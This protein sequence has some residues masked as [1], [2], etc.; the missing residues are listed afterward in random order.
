MFKF[1]YVLYKI[2]LLSPIGL[3]RLA[4]AVCKCGINLMSLLKYA[5]MAYGEKIALVY[6]NE[7]ITYKQLLVESQT[8]SVALSQKY[9][10]NERHKVGFLCRN[11]EVMVKAL[12]A[13]SA[14]G[15]N[16][17]LLNVEVSHN[18]F[19]TLL[20]SYDID[21]LIYDAEFEQLV[22]DS[23]Y[24]KDK[25]LS[26]HCQSLAMKHLAQS[27]GSIDLPR[28]IGGAIMML[29]GG[30]TGHF[31]VAVHKPSVFRFLKPFLVLIH[32]LKLYN[33]NC[34]YIAT[35]IYH[36]YG[37]SMLLV[38]VALGK[39]IVIDKGYDTKR[40]CHLIDRY[41][42]DAVT[43]VPLMLNKMLNEDPE[44]LKSLRC[45]ASGG[46]LLNSRLVEQT[47]SLLGDVLYNLY[48]TSEA[49][50]NVIATPMDLKYC[51][52]T[53]GKKIEGTRI[54]IFDEKLLEK[55]TNETGQICIKNK[56]S[57]RIGNSSWVKTGDLGYKDKEGYYFLC[58][59]V[60]DMIVSAGENVYPIE[61]ERVLMQHPQIIDAAVIG[62]ADEA[63]GQR[64]KA[65]VQLSKE[66]PLTKEELIEW[67]RPNVARFQ[68]PKE[69][70][71]VESIAYTSLFK[72]DIKKLM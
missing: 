70:V 68:M 13:V 30:T 42:V 28:N 11:H 67:L 69:I 58:G 62:V 33:C 24:K 3:F 66:T 34:A 46:A 59:R 10:L 22:I 2:G 20:N 43:V 37:I 5:A 41:K 26:C 63:F 49:G 51:A 23:N 12:F 18:Q 61:V 19:N 64:L 15:A 47:L 40:A 55:G 57:T 48:G 52:N 7:T 21:L 32:R 71:F 38:F 36:G 8:L 72:K 17:Y 1:V 56:W 35:P 6:N 54:K 60:D 16:I 25:L 50:L 44:A 9:K 29:T 45:I 4:Y 14:I 31:K 39:N 27:N 53:I 65:F